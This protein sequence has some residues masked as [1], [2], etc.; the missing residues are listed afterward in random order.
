[1]FA[2]F[3]KQKVQNTMN[4]EQETTFAMAGM[5]LEDSH[6]VPEVDPALSDEDK[7]EFILKQMT[8]EEKI[9]MLG[10]VD[11]LAIK[12]NE[13]LNLP[14]V[15]CSDASAGVRCFKRATAFPVP[16]AMA[17][18]WNRKQIQV[19]G[20]TIGKECRAKGVSILLGPGVN[21]YRVPTYGRNFEYL[22]EDPYL[23]AELAVPYIQGVQ[24]MGV[25]TTVKHFA[26]NNSDY[27]RHRANSKV[28]E[29]TLREIYLPA[30][31]A[32]VQKG[33]VHSVMTAY[34]PVNGVFASENETLVSDI[35]RKEWG[36]KG[37]VI[38]DWISVYDT[39]GP[40]KA[41][42][43][44]EMPKGDYLNFKRIQKLIKKGQLT[45]A[46]IDRPVRNLLT[47]FFKM[48][49][50]SR[51]LKDSRYPEFSEEHSNIA[52]DTAREGIVLLK[53]E[54]KLLPLDK[55]KI[56]SVAVVGKMAK[57]TTTCAGGSCCILSYDKISILDGIK[58][59]VGGEVEVIYL[60]PHKGKLT[61]PDCQ[62]LKT[63]D[64]VI[65]SAG[66]TNVDESEAY[67]KT[68]ELPDQQ[69]ELIKSVSQL[70][71]KVIVTL[72]TGTGVESES[73]LSGVSALLH[74]FYLGDRS[75]KAVA[76]VLFGV[77]NPSGKLPFSMV[78]RWEDIEAAKYYVK[79]PDKISLLRILGPQGMP[80]IRK[81]WDMEYG[82]KLMV[83][84]RNLDTNQIEPQFPFGFGLSYTKFNLSGL[85][86]SSQEISK[87]DLTAGGSVKVTLTV[88][89]TGSVAGA[90]VVQ[91]YVKDPESSLP[92]P[93]KELKG[94]EK[95][96]LQPGETGDI[97]FVISSEHLAYFDDR[98]NQ[99]TVEAGEFLILIGSSSR[100]I[101]L[102]GQ[103]N[104]V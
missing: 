83:G 100:D 36:F 79:K 3:I 52:L 101:Q 39:E 57:D 49:I 84:Y 94:F 6:V 18:T 42:L 73:W 93:E 68:W 80:R 27:D 103:V 1:M 102:Q 88:K 92:R 65:V 30:F 23:A 59:E 21:I 69:A 104:V 75:G 74:C 34:N 25:V 53:N 37:F 47:T 50:Y 20:E 48:G 89:N 81:I 4:S 26:C 82:E 64:V 87:E 15:W 54:N 19:V 58:A 97:S 90:E 56:S 86:L 38:S 5:E 22:G 2:R 45:E 77:V 67:D 33:G 14:K 72:T 24:S 63:V 61:E 12:G 98:I 71:S 91:L 13:R 51:P 99:W 7:A 62:K 70:N 35:L 31:K 28:D 60:E 17:A 41:G 66:F 55:Q 76:D 32:A 43:D 9:D 16:I 10:G 95:I 8:L 46:D 11:N 44:L 29:R 78:K 40:L 85:T 96:R